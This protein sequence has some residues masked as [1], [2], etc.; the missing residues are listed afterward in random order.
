MNYRFYRFFIF[1]VMVSLF[2]CFSP[3]LSYGNEIGDEYSAFRLLD[4]SVIPGK[5]ISLEISFGNLIEKEGEALVPLICEMDAKHSYSYVVASLDISEEK[6]N[7]TPIPINTIQTVSLVKGYNRIL[8]LLPIQKLKDGIYYGNLQVKYTKEEK[9]AIVVFQIEKISSKGLEEQLNF[10]SQEVDNVISLNKDIQ[11]D[12]SVEFNLIKNLLLQARNEFNDKHWEDLSDTLNI[13]QEQ[14]SQLKDSLPKSNAT[15]I[16]P[17]KEDLS[18]SITPEGVFS[19]KKPVNVIGI[20]LNEPTMDN[21]K[22][23]IDYAIPVVVFPI[24]LDKMFPTESGEQTLP[25]DIMGILDYLFENKVYVLFQIVQ[26]QVPPWLYEKTPNIHKDGF[27]DLSQRP[28]W[29]LIEKGYKEIIN[30]C[31]E[32]SFFLGMS[33]V[34][35]PKFKFDGDFVRQS[36]IEWVKVNYPDRQT[37]NQ[38]WHAHL[39]NYEEITIWDE[40]APH[41]SYQNR[42]AYQYDW[43]NFH[44]EM[45]SNLLK[46]A[47]DQFR[48]FSSDVP[49]SI[50]FPSTVFELD[51]TKYTPDREQTIPYLDF[52][53]ISV[54]FNTEDTVYAQGYPDPAVDVVWMRSVSKGK[55]IIISSANLNFKEGMTDNEKYKHTQSFLWEMALAGAQIVAVNITGDLRDNVEIWKAIFDTNSLFL[56]ISPELRQFQLSKAMVRVLFSD[57]SKILDG[58][59][60]HLKS[61]RFAYEGSSFA[62]YDVCFATEKG[63]E[64]GILQD[65]KVLIMPQ[66]L[67]LEDDVFNIITDFIRNGNYVIRVGT[68]IPYDP[69]GMSRR[70]VV[71]PTSN[72]IL[73][74]GMNLPTE[75]LHGMD[76]LISKK[77]LA[78]I[79]RPVNKVGYPLEGIKSR[80]IPSEDGGGYLYLLN[81]RKEKVL[82]R[83]TGYLQKGYSLMD[84]TEI[85]FPRELQPLELIFMKMV[86]PDYEKIVQIEPLPTKKVE[87]KKHK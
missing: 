61:A 72:T 9:P 80:F 52:I 7:E 67:S 19:N 69:K 60:P 25:A 13:L 46:G 37:L 70:D 24:T 86:P 47:L 45:I 74:R 65:T 16:S 41:W 87:K 63:I 83:L 20:Y 44:R 15:V 8:F 42:R 78:S 32:K 23:V 35:E 22:M 84:N 1:A 3:C 14:I 71:Q 12:K 76:A 4:K 54:S 38:V 48:L 79:P 49:V 33:L 82:C 30:Y 73:V 18:L 53:P 36:F 6:N 85:E 64:T 66:T 31:K 55:P 21:A 59:T 11:N 50:T 17:Q 75:Y 57:S 40:V 29:D 62:G 28:V 2:L 68:Q 10:V 56:K 27:V 26:E 77:A 43:Q 34:T 51:E 81:L 58:G 5:N 39:A